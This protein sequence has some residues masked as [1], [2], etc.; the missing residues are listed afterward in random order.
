[1]IKEIFFPLSVGLML[2]LTGMKVMQTG[3]YNLAGEQLKNVLLRFTKTPF[4]GF[5][6]GTVTTAIV[7]S[8]SA[9]TLLTIALTGSRMLTFPQTI[10]IILGANVGTT[11][12][13][14]IIALDLTQYAV[15]IFFIGSALWLFPFRILRCFGLFIGGFGL[16]FLGLDL[17]QWIARP[18]MQLPYLTNMVEFSHDNSVIGILMG[19]VIT[20]IIQSST[21]TTAITM[22]LMDEYLIPLS[23]GIAII[24]GSN[25]GT[26]ITAWL[27]SLGG[28]IEGKRVA[29]AHILIN[30]IG[31]LLFIPLIGVLAVISAMVT[32]DP[33]SQLAHAQTIFNVLCSLFA[34][35]FSGPF[36][37]LVSWLISAKPS[38]G[39]GS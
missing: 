23:M 30:V 27:G 7:Q 20:A 29:W 12:T 37:R 34:L 13:T 16:I 2:F 25:V 39:S 28:S 22:G 19:T 32:A 24:L 26:C 35:P 15:F 14:E 1:M 33:P 9:V 21:A 31:V 3:L 36:A 5:I 6:T 8:S 18:L 17:I 4:H 11:I 10:G 38:S